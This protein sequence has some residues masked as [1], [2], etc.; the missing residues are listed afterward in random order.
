M[1]NLFDA[2]RSPS[3]LLFVLVMFVQL[4]MLTSSVNREHVGENVALEQEQNT[5]ITQ[6]PQPLQYAVS[7]DLGNADPTYHISKQPDGSY[8]TN[9]PR[10]GV[11][12]RLQPGNLQVNAGAHSW[13]LSLHA[14]GRGEALDP[15]PAAS[16]EQLDANCLS[17]SRGGLTEWYRNGPLGL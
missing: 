17:F 13:S 12:A 6:L 15:L 2:T 8:F 14:W 4:S 1:I 7:R 5:E 3:R 10:S 9:E 11:Q 16:S